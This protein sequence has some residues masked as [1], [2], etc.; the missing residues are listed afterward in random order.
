MLCLPFFAATIHLP[1]DPMTD[2][3]AWPWL[4]AVGVVR[5]GQILDISGAVNTELIISAD[6]SDARCG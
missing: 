3:R 6:G 4:V 1:C 2:E 5:S